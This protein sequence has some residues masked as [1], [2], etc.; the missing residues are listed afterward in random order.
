MDLIRE[1]YPLMPKWAE[2]ELTS[3]VTTYEF[4][5]S[6]VLPHTPDRYKTLVEEL[7]EEQDPFMEDGQPDTFVEE[8]KHEP[9]ADDCVQTASPIVKHLRGR[10]PSKIQIPSRSSSPSPP[11]ISRPVLKPT[12]PIAKPVLRRTPP[13][14]SVPETPQSQIRRRTTSPTSELRREAQLLFLGEK[15]KRATELE[16]L[17]E[18]GGFKTNLKPKSH[19]RTGTREIPIRVYD[20]EAAMTSWGTVEGS[21]SDE[22]SEEISYDGSGDW[23]MDLEEAV[24]HRKYLYRILSRDMGL[25]EKCR[26]QREYSSLS[27]HI[28]KLRWLKDE[29]EYSC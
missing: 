12:P 18:R 13:V 20:E 27:R 29:Q 16:S 8:S 10:Q 22:E 21:S 24:E 26:R 1:M 6:Q 3:F 7:A 4:R 19:R 28:R 23:C 17:R 25:V 14:T 2:N 11:S 5:Y 15:R 9:E